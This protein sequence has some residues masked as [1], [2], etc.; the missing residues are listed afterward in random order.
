M[1]KQHTWDLY[2]ES[3]VFT[4]LLNVIRVRSLFFL[5]MFEVHMFVLKFT[6]L[7]TFIAVT[8]FSSNVLISIFNCEK[9]LK[10]TFIEFWFLEKWSRESKVWWISRY[11]Q[12]NCEVR[13][14]FHFRSFIKYILLFNIIY[15]GVLSSSKYC[16]S[17]ISDS[18]LG[19]YSSS[20]VIWI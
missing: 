9:I 17:F 6:H 13:V 3:I 18:G 4:P 10:F 5:V 7:S 2:R 15:H 20:D 1:Y 12:R 11:M 14:S 19:G 8:T 16:S